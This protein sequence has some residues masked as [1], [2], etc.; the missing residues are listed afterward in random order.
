M[1]NRLKELWVLLDWATRGKLLGRQKEFEQRYICMYEYMCMLLNLA[2]SR[3]IIRRY[4]DP[5]SKGQDPKAS[6]EQ[7]SISKKVAK[8][9]L[10]TIR[11][12]YMSACV[13]I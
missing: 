7:Q 1:Q 8:S 4:A 12:V 11:S 5:I 2:L 9:L 13:N 10:N 3:I 6:N